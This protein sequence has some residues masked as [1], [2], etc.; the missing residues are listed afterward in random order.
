MRIKQTF[1]AG[2][3]TIYIG[4]FHSRSTA[5]DHVSV[6][7]KQSLS[8]EEKRTEKRNNLSVAK[9]KNTSLV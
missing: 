5:L 4:N 9:S 1:P 7:C 3:E 8:S 2:F 6:G